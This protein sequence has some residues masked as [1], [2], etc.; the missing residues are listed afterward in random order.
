MEV[1]GLGVE[2]QLQ[3]QAYATATATP[4]LS[5]TCDLHHRLG[6]AWI[7]S[8]LSEARVQTCILMEMCRVPN[9]LSHNRNSSN[10]S[11]ESIYSLKVFKGMIK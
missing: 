7:L 1:P 9:L 2:L 10:I 4:A 6:Q 11:S 3:L 8:P 5:Y